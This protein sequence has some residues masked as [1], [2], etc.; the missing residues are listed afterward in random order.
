VV[1][2][3]GTTEV[4][5]DPRSKVLSLIELAVGKTT[6]PH[7]A[8]AAAMAACRK[9]KAEGLLILRLVEED[10]GHGSYR[11]EIVLVDVPFLVMSQSSTLY[12]VAKLEPPK[13]HSSEIFLI[14]KEFVKSV[15]MMT[16]EE[17]R[18]IGWKSSSVIKSMR[19][20][21]SYFEQARQNGWDRWR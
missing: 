9:I 12:R 13:G 6:P 7:E 1:A 4:A 18:A 14:P 11:E 10:S 8:A 20:D 15:V 3:V 16:P 5:T 21:R 2:T 17:T 19:I